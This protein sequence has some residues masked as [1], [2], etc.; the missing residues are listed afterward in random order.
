MTALIVGTAL[1]V[2]SLCYVLYPLLRPNAALGIIPRR[3]K[4][5]DAGSSSVDALR[6]LE[7]DRQTGKIS[8]SDYGTLKARYTEEALT[9]MRAAGS[10]SAAC[11][12]CGP[13]PEADAT[14]CSDCG[15]RLLA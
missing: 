4:G 8:D 13:R 6:E 5:R 3:P 1:A 2:A 9:V 10:G 12:N 7:F 11:P 15:A 14:F